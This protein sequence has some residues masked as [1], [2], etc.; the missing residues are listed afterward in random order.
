[1]G[2]GKD[3]DAGKDWRQRRRGIER[4]RC[5][6]SITNSMDMNLSKLQEIVEDREAWRAAVHGVAKSWTWLN[7][8]TTAA[9]LAITEVV[10]M[11][12]NWLRVIVARHGK[13]TKTNCSKLWPTLSQFFLHLWWAL[14]M[15]LWNQ[16]RNLRK[17][18]RKSCRSWDNCLEP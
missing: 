9:T 11:F 13:L 8:W 7:G 4:M 17:L 14:R 10:K 16:K 15:D 18:N 3:P 12:W 6:D 1:M 5:L 2:W